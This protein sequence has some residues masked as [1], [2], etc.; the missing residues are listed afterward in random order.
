VDFQT[1]NDM[2]CDGRLE[3]KTSVFADGFRMFVRRAMSPERIRFAVAHEICHTFFYEFVPEMKFSSPRVDRQE[4]RLCNFGAA[5]LLARTSR[6]LESASGLPASMKSLRLIASTFGVSAQAMFVR[7]KSLNLWRCQMSVWSRMTNGE[8]LLDRIYGGRRVDWHWQDESVV[9]RALIDDGRTV[10]SGRTFVG[11]K[12]E[13]GQN[14]VIPAYYQVTKAGDSVLALW[15]RT[16]FAK[17]KGPASLFSPL[18][19]RQNLRS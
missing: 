3:P 14:R 1:A 17:G 4:E 7:L 6:V 8:I 9:R 19:K 5:E 10:Y 2:S 16:P 11:F 18:G 15:S 12:D 13:I